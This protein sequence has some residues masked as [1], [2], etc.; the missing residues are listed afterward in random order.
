MTSDDENVA[1][2]RAGYVAFLLSQLRDDLDDLVAGL[3]SGAI[4]D[5]TAVAGARVQLQW[6]LTELTKLG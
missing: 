5:D 3:E 6:G 4:T 1:R 2:K